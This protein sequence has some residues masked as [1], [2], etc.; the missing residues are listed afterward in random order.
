MGIYKTAFCNTSSV[1]NQIQKHIEVIYYGIHGK[2]VFTSILTV[3]LFSNWINLAAIITVTSLGIG[4]FA[5]QSVKTF[6]CGIPAPGEAALVPVA[7]NISPYFDGVLPNG[8]TGSMLTPAA[9]DRLKLFNTGV[10][11]ALITGLAGSQSLKSLPVECPTGNCT[12]GIFGN[13][14]YFSLAFDSFCT[15]ASELLTQSNP[16]TWSLSTYLSRI[17]TPDLLWANYSIGDSKIA[18]DVE[19]F[20][21]S[22]HYRRWHPAL[23]MGTPA[24]STELHLTLSTEE[25][26]I[27]NTD[28]FAIHLMIPRSSPCANDT[29]GLY[30]TDSDDAQPLAAVNTN[31]CETLES[32]NVTSY[33][34][35]FTLTAA[36]C[37]LY[38]SLRSYLGAIVNGQLQ[39]RPAASPKH[40]IRAQG[41]SYTEPRAVPLFAFADPCIINNTVYSTSNYS[42]APDEVA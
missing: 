4:T 28:P 16:I 10:K 37:Y 1:S 5:Q 27:R 7:Q 8:T 19:F 9:S 25:E 18:Y 38:P 40:L 2:R 39:E 13:A 42:D 23:F 6:T 15:D 17:G 34:G 22:V 24:S 35:S 26:E 14:N 33:P 29:D 11:I 20:S 3:I 12:F 30:Q 31:L 36:V 21:S 41:F 32:G